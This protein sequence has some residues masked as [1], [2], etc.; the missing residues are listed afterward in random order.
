M[1]TAVITLSAPDLLVIG[2]TGL[3]GRRL[4]ASPGGRVAATHHRSPPHSTGPDWHPLNLRDGGAQ[5]AAL[6]ES[7]RPRSVV[8]AAYVQGGDDLRTVTAEA[9]GAIAAA[10]RHVGARFVHV[11]TDVVFDGTTPRPYVE[12]DPPS[13]VHDY[14]RAKADAERLVAS[15]D[16]TA[17]IVRTSLLYGDPADP[18]PQVEMTTDP[19]VTFYNDEF[20]SPLPVVAL[21][22]ACLELAGRPEITG[23]LHVAGSETMDR[24]EFARMVAPLVGIDPATLRGGPGSVDTDRP[25]NCPLDSRLA[26]SLLS[27]ALP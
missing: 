2:A 15:A 16:P 5:A 19:D 8:N 17:V 20:R 23:L 10:C 13:P 6:I 4:L 11:S 14:G 18:G 3:L 24:L 22:A 26:R 7:I 1:S 21:A 12:S 25:S 9:P 27:T